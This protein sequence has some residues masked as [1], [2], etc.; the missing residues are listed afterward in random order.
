M[1]MYINTIGCGC[2]QHA[3]AEADDTGDYEV[4]NYARQNEYISFFFLFRYQQRYAYVCM[5]TP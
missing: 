3:L 1:C 5:Y 2:R 4:N